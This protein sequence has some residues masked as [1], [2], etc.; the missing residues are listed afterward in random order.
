MVMSLAAGIASAS[1]A[2]ASPSR[3]GRAGRSADAVAGSAGDVGEDENAGVP[4]FSLEGTAGMTEPSD[5]AAV[6]HPSLQQ[7]LAARWV[8]SR[9]GRLAAA[10]GEGRVQMPTQKQAERAIAAQR[11]RQRAGPQ[12]RQSVEKAAS[13]Q[14][15]PQGAGKRKRGSEKATGSG[16]AASAHK[17]DQSGGSKDKGWGPLPFQTQAN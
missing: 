8:P 4:G 3:G 1:K 14:D 16:S 9:P 7:P 2:A 17:P 15:A 12:T 13:A 6:M 5:V 10:D 11:E